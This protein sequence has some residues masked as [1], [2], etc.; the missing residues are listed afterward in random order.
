MQKRTLKRNLLATLVAGVLFVLAVPLTV[1]AISNH[2]NAEANQ[3]VQPTAET[4]TRASTVASQAAER[5][6]E[7]EARLTDARLRA[8]QNR[9]TVITNIM[10]R[11]SDRGQ[12]QL[13]LFSGIATRVENFYT[14]KGKILSNYATLVADVNAKQ[15]A[16][17]LAVNAVKSSSTA[18]TCDGT[19]PMGVADSFKSMLKIEIS[20]LNDYKT[21]IKNLIVGVKSVESQTATTTNA[22]TTTKATT[23]TTSTTGTTG[24]NQ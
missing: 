2:A 3:A 5:K 9:Q 10:T 17:Q 15:S 21:S 7:V 6:V 24:G 1:A 11:I 14:S 4:S 20:S 23:S 13:D 18:F 19:N 8:C 22:D 16:A 12:K